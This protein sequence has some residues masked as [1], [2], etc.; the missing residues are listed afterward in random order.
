MGKNKKII[1]TEFVL[2]HLLNINF[3]NSL[4]KRVYLPLMVNKLFFNSI[5]I[6][7]YP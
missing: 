3:N 4:K 7:L 6:S 2:K 1:I 5:I